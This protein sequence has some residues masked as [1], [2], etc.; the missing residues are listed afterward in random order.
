[1]KRG[2]NPKKAYDAGP[3]GKSVM[4]DY[5]TAAAQDVRFEEIEFAVANDI[6]IM[7]RIRPQP[8]LGHRKP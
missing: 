7:S 5:L 3:S 6:N 2:P 4:P 1:M 8:L